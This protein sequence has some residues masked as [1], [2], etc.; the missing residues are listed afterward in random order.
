MDTV[1]KIYLAV[2][3]V[4]STLIVGLIIWIIILYHGLNDL[5]D[6][7][8][9]NSAQLGVLQNNVAGFNNR[10]PPGPSG[11]RG[12]PGPAGPSGGTNLGRGPLR[13]LDSDGAFVVDRLHGSGKASIAFLNK[14]SYQPN[15]IWTYENNNQI[16]NQ[17]GGCLTGDAISGEVYMNGC[18]A[19][20]VGQKWQQNNYGQISLQ[21]G[22]QCLDVSL[23]SQFNGANKIVRGSELGKDNNHFNIRTLKL[24]QC[25]KPNVLS[26]TQQFIFT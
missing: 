16:S 3:I 10:G 1:T 9:A 20:A 4:I 11:E 17:Y 2:G 7:Y 13:N 18:D 8:Q 19:N 5:N 22:G 21:E 26:P 14:L 15:Q 24:K 6:K 12:P 25:N 23:E